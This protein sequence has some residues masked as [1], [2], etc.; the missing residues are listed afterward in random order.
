MSPNK[1]KKRK[2]N[3]PAGGSVPGR[4][5]RL[6]VPVRVGRVR[7][8]DR[9]VVARHEHRPH[10]RRD[11]VAIPGLSGRSRVP[12]E[13]LVLRFVRIQVE[14]VLEV[15][16]PVGQ[17]PGGEVLRRERLDVQDLRLA[18]VA[19]VDPGDCDATCERNNRSNHPKTDLFS[20]H[21]PSSLSEN[22]SRKVPREHLSR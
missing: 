19:L 11:V 18:V 22:R 2:R 9:V 8:A 3:S 4:V 1:Y 6:Q 21:S 12:I 10:L 7:I 17:R 13:R 14:Q 15:P 5:R 20:E 16:D